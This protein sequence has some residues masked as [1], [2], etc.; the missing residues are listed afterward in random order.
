MGNCVCLSL[1]KKQQEIPKVVL[2]QRNDEEIEEDIEDT[3]YIY[4]PE[5]T[6]PLLDS[7]IEID[8]ESIQNISEICSKYI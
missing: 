7:E 3:E 6:I 2:A 5:L 4:P 1:N 8:N